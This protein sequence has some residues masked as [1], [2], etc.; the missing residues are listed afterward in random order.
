MIYGIVDVGSNTIR[1]TIYQYEN[2]ELSSLLHKKTMAGLAGYVEQGEMSQKG[3]EKACE[4]VSE[5]KEILN[6]FSI[7]NLNVFATASLRNIVNTNEVVRTIRE[8][9]GVH[10]DVI[11]GEEEAQLDFIGATHVINMQDGLLVDIGGGSTELVSY[12]RGQIV[13][14]VSMPIGS[15]SLFTKHVSKL[16]P[17]KSEKHAI[18]EE[19]RFELDKLFEFDENELFQE[20]C[21][22]G[23]TIRAACKLNNDLLGSEARNSIDCKHLGKMLKILNKRKKDT[24]RRI[25]RVVPDRIHTIIPGMLILNE[26]ATYFGSEVIRISNYGVREGYLY[27]KVLKDGGQSAKG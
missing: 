17:K 14:A 20:I 9:T 13:T 8:L 6:N 26:I 18:V 25:L 23:G 3:I 22:V 1:L 19:I 16:L 15:L 4:I 7:C 27:S 11:S 2:G 5:Y 12:R 21:G 10:V 24:Y